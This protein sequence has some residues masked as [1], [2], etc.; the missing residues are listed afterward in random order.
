MLEEF[1]LD[2]KFLYK[3]ILKGE[4]PSLEDFKAKWNIN[5]SLGEAYQ[6]LSKREDKK[7]T[8][9]FYTPY[10]V[11]DYM[12]TEL[13]KK[14]DLKSNPKLKILDPSCGGG[15]FL[16]ALVRKLADT[17]NQ[18]DEF[19]RSLLDNNIYGFDIDENAV[20]IS[21]I[22]LYDITG[23][24]ARNIIL[25]DF[26]L[27]DEDSYDFVI[28]NPPYMGH[29]VLKGDYRESLKNKYSDVFKD[30]GDLAYCFIKKAID[31]LKP[32][33]VLNFFTSR[34]IL[35][36]LNGVDIRKYILDNGQIIRMIDF[37]GIRV[38]KGAGV[39]TVI[40]D[41]IKSNSN[42]IEYIDFYRLK[43]PAKGM[44]RKVFDEINN[45]ALCHKVNFGENRGQFTF[46]NIIDKMC[47]IQDEQM[48]SLD[49]SRETEFIKNIHIRKSEL[50]NEGWSF[51]SKAENRIISKIKGPRLGDICVSYQGIITGCDEAFVI[52]DKDAQRLGIE[53]ELLKP[54]IKGKNV[55]KFRVGRGNEYLIYSDSISQEAL[56]PKAVEYISRCRSRL[57]GRRECIK[58]TRRWFEL[59]WGRNAEIFNGIKIIF[60]YKSA[61]NRFAIDR[62]SF[63]SAD[64]YALKLNESNVNEYSYEYLEGVLNSSIYEFYIKT[65]A[66]KLGDDLYEYYP[67]KIMNIRVPGF[68]KK[69]EDEVKNNVD[70]LRDRIDKL[71]M[72]Y[73]GIDDGEY[74][75]IKDWCK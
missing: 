61:T 73:F 14:V 42:K 40:I 50:S 52:S 7:E 27:E 34:Y 21:V 51:L 41:F 31:S 29:K 54:W 60:P 75:V 25:K 12:V 58:G 38:V 67:N 22:E 55:D 30:K 24:V 62:G 59:Q 10:E 71:L 28:G 3:S 43:N 2:I 13:V 47:E 23:H 4:K 56:Y 68:V 32:G 45:M 9:S 33:G 70:G 39:D 6:K 57:E 1:I 20:M 19:Y 17:Q 53:N 49:Y 48:E 11:V 63:F 44:G 72:D 35:E 66:K 64:V 26:L 69:I 36:A 37:Y 46:L 5:N 8:G 15:Y 18:I 74:E 65:V 16:T